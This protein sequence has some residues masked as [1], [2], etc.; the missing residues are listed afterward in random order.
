MA[1]RPSPS[2]TAHGTLSCPSSQKD[3]VEGNRTPEVAARDA[4]RVRVARRPRG[5]GDTVIFIRRHA[6]PV[7]LLAHLT[8]AP[9]DDSNGL[10]SVRR[11]PRT[12]V[13][14]DDAVSRSSPFTALERHVR[15]HRT[16]RCVEG[17]AHRSA[18]SGHSWTPGMDRLA[19]FPAT[20]SLGSFGQAV[21]CAAPPRHATVSL[22]RAIMSESASRFSLSRFLVPFVALSMLALAGCV[23]YDDRGAHPA[24]RSFDIPKGHMPPPG[25]CRI[26][27]PDRPPGQQPPPGD[28]HD[29]RRK[30]PRGA[31][32]IHG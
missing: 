23:A 11:F 13:G 1:S 27:L 4:R 26:W 15:L 28:C 10:R 18:E 12:V 21:M 32:L 25:K 29:L 16:P 9:S 6:C 24:S 5:L 20:L 19:V 3:H 7:C 14:C 17:C 31:A 22:W 2:H 30:V 8:S